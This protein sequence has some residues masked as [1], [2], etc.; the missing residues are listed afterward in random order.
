MSCCG[1]KR[2]NGNGAML[3]RT[4]RVASPAAHTAQMNQKQF[5]VC[6]EYFGKTGMTVLGLASGKRYRFNQAGSRVFIDPR[7]R[8]SM[9]QVPN[10]KE[11]ALEI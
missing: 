7:D 1:Q 4:H 8:P 10:L 11:V 6:F 5:V 3:Y 9:L 2:A